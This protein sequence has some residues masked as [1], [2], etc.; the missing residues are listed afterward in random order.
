MARAALYLLGALMLALVGF[1]GYEAWRVL[2]ARARTPALIQIALNDADPEIATV[3]SAW[4]DALIA[5]EDPSFYRNDGL[6][7]KS[8]GQ[9][10]TTLTQGLAKRLYYKR[11]TPGL[12]HLGKLDLMLVSK[13]ALAARASKDKILLATLAA[14]YLG[15]DKEGPVIG[16]A[17]GARRWYGRELSDL[18]FDSWL[19]LVAMMIAPNDLDPM[20]HGEANVERVLRIKRLLTKECRPNGHL[21][22]ALDACARIAG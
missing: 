15:N 17:E 20:R 2:D 13:Y 4:T 9:G 12:L 1:A 16:F 5:V 3:P 6:D 10:T 21:D 22:V 19:G 8:P 14:A 7:F 11:F 18:D